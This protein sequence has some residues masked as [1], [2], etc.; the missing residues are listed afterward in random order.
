MIPLK[1][2][3]PNLVFFA[4]SLCWKGERVRNE[5]KRDLV[6]GSLPEFPDFVSAAT[7]S[8]PSSRELGMARS[9]KMKALRGYAGF[10]WFHL[11]HFGT[12][13]FW[14]HGQLRPLVTHLFWQAPSRSRGRW[15]KGGRRNK[16]VL[17]YGRAIPPTMVIA[18]IL[19]VG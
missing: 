11:P 14:S 12:L 3:M 1:R 19:D 2:C 7:P 4:I 13:F 17:L 9:I 15:S 8:G 18:Y 6:I 10:S 5:C 16:R